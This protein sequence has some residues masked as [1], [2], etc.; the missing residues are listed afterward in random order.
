MVRR[1]FSITAML[2][3]AVLVIA[4]D[5]S[6]ARER[7]LGRR[8]RDRRDGNVV[9]AE[10]Y[11]EAGMPV[12]TETGGRRANYPPESPGLSRRARSVLLEV[13]VPPDAEIWIDGT[14]T[15]T[16]G[17]VRQFIS[18]PIESGRPYTYK[19]EA[20]WMDNGQERKRTEEVNVRPGQVARLDLTRPS[21]DKQ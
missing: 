2:A 15:L 9:Y 12:A 17:A 6:Q 19:V 1:W 8:L 3:V 4:A 13:R 7:R 5:A 20:K 16:K 11:T 10:T 18:P 14:K 21:E